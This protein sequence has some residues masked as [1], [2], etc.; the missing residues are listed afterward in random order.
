V[1]AHESKVTFFKQSGWMV[2][3]T[4]MSGAFL[5]AVYPILGKLPSEEVG[6]YVSLLRLFTLL[7]IGAAG[8]QIVMAQDA[9]AAITDELKLRLAATVRSVAKGVFGLWLLMLLVCAPLQ[10][11]IV[12]T[13]KITNPLAVWI[14]MALVLAQL[15][16]PF[17]Q[18]LLQGMQNFAWLGWSIMLNGL[19]R[20]IAIAVAVI[21][22]KG[23][24]AGALAGA[25][26]GMGAAVFAGY[27]PS[28][29]LFRLRG[30]TFRWMEWLKRLVPLSAGVGSVLVVMNA[31]MLFVQAHFP[32]D[33]SKF[34]AAV[35]MV[36]I[37][38]V[39][40]TTPMASVMFPKLVTSVAKGQRSNSFMLALAGTALLGIF[41]A[42]ACTVLPE[43]PLRILFF[44][45]PEFWV[46]SQLIPWFMWC[47]L[48]VTVANV[49]VSDLLAKRR[50]AI[51]PWLVLIAIAYCWAIHQF[52]GT[53]PKEDHFAAFK[54]VIQ[55]LGIF[56]ML[57]L[58]VAGAFSFFASRGSRKETN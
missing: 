25:L 4:S 53:I 38:L 41:G 56:A 37:G 34:Y 23:H 26:V 43:L 20:V 54:G 7:G 14:T 46:S 30:G 42:L 6:I 17:V 8:L 55:R 33:Q 10:E 50:F 44:N 2:I 11:Q 19:A 12:S 5:I 36:G 39:T 31:D 57:L 13:F 27:W 45:K 52:L 47:M 35:A 58:L 21:L 48:P 1:T 40:F 16:L 9:A 24:S 32:S 29:H 18:G 3:A 15:L 49:M 51:V 28:R 22:F